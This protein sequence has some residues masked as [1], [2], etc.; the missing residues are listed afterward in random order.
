MRNLG[1]IILLITLYL[2]SI[3]ADSVKATVSNTSLIS[4]NRV[5]LSIKAIGDNIVFPRIKEVSGNMVISSSDSSYSS[6]TFGINGRKA[7]ISKTRNISFLAEDNLT[8]P[9][10]S[11]TIN[12]K[13]YKT[14]PIDI[15]VIKS[16]SE[17]K[18]KDPTF[19]L[20]LKVDKDRVMVGESLMVTAYFALKSGVRLSQKIRYTPPN[21][22]GFLVTDG[23]QGKEYMKDNYQIQ[24]LHY[25]ITPQSEGNFTIAPAKAQIGVQDRVRRDVFG[26]VFGTQWK[27]TISNI[28]NIEVLAQP[29]DSDMI[30]DYKISSK[31][32][33]QSVKANKPVNLTIE[34]EGRGSLESFEYPN[35]DIDGVTIYSNEAKITTKVKNNEIYSTYTKGFVFISDKDFTIPSREFSMITLKEHKLKVLAIES[36]DIKVDSFNHPSISPNQGVIQSKEKQQVKIKEVIV[37][38]IVKVQVKGV[39]WWMLIVAFGLGILSTLIIRWIPKIAFKKS[40]NNSQSLKILYPHISTNP[41][42][43]DMVRRL[44]ASQNGD[45]SVVIDKK[46][47]REMVERFV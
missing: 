13:V 15:R 36:F 22:S 44:Y 4:G 25:I 37:E 30:G 21:F 28:V 40:Y 6:Y 43:E 10:Y 38:K 12:G 11:V 8:I 27:E 29:K 24:E 35:Y 20:E 7:E 16:K 39:E 9:S 47:L 5:N 32:D 23:T 17:I 1:K 26:M 41:E 2:S 42:V 45:K 18:E 19:Y 14:S 46:E 3:Y 31:I 33:T 34:I